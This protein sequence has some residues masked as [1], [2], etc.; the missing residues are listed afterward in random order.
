MGIANKH[1]T[2]GSSLIS[3]KRLW[4]ILENVPTLLRHF[5]SDELRGFL[6]T[7]E[8]VE[9]DA[10]NILY[11]EQEGEIDNGWLIVSGAVRLSK[12]NE[13]LQVG[14]PGEFLGETFL[15]PSG[16]PL[17]SAITEEPSV[18]IRFD[19]KKVVEFFRKSPERLFMRFIRNLL[20]CQRIKIEQQYIRQIQLTQA[21]SKS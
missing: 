21:N 10:G 19:R 13:L 7:G 5:S 9:L 16:P 20:E 12:Q 17:T 8:L 6:N 18:V 2:E 3:D 4:H 1:K 14:H 11:Q 15:F